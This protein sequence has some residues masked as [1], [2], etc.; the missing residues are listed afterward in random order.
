MK[1]LSAVVNFS[2]ENKLAY[3]VVFYNAFHKRLEFL[4][5]CNMCICMYD[6]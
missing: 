1:V 4:Y 3:N 6:V 5:F 2:D